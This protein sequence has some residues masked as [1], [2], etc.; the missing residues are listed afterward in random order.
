MEEQVALYDGDGQVV[1]SAPRSR[2]RAEN[3]HHGA[4]A[5][6]V[7]DSWGRVYVHRRSTG[8]DVYP[9]LLDFC[10]GGV[11]QAGEDPRESAVREVGEELGVSGVPL[12]PSGEGSYA[13][14]ATS[15]H[16]YL[17]SVT[18]DGPIRWQPEEVVWGEWVELDELRRHLSR[19]PQDFVP[20]ST[21][22]WSPRLDAWASDRLELSRVWDSVATLV[23]GRWVDRSPRRP[24][25]EPSLLAEVELMPV[26]AARVPLE[27]PVPRLVSRDPLRVRHVV[28][29]GDPVDPGRLAGADGLVLGQFLR[30]LHAIPL[31]DLPAGS[32]GVSA[33]RE[34]RAAQLCEFERT[35]LPLLPTDLHGAGRR[36]IRDLGVV[37]EQTLTHADLVPEHLLVRDGRVTGVIDWGDARVTDPA[38]DLAW[39][40]HGTPAGFADA[41][42][43]AYGVT[44]EQDRRSLLWYALIPWFDAHRGV[45]LG[46]PSDRDRG[47]AAAAERLRRLW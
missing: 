15:Y 6:V 27:V 3:L 29:E 18:Y 30:H 25:V 20:D 5:V 11:V 42:R 40:L 2:V 44:S 7:R 12:V 47:L 1:G 22:L 34:D 24:E 8:K 28:V 23:E 35:V 45:F 32:P 16:A 31:E 26:V 9:G 14:D 10:A 38:L 21:A 4:T 37:G 36:L 39:L 43:T 19:G 46:D 13:D 41:L 33:D 17:Y